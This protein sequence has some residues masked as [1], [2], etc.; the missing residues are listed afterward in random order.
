[1]GGQ[2]KKDLASAEQTKQV[3]AEEIGKLSSAL[4][5][6]KEK[7]QELDQLNEDLE[8]R[9]QEQQQQQLQHSKMVATEA[10]P[11]LQLQEVS[12]A[13]GEEIPALTQANTKLQQEVSTLTEQ[14][15]QTRATEA[16]GKKAK[17][18]L[19]QAEQQVSE[20]K[21][22][23]QEAEEKREAEIEVL[24]THIQRLEAERSEMEE[25]ISQLHQSS[26]KVATAEVE[27][28]VPKGPADSAGDGIDYN[29]RLEHMENEKFSMNEQ[30]KDLKIQVLNKQGEVGELKT[31]L[32]MCLFFRFHSIL[33]H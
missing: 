23:T 12:P 31:K 14:L 24:R 8:D 25:K 15:R 20:L 13:Q 5:R 3:H 10:P 4:E 32:G 29:L 19:L 18:S 21:A 16:E 27:A 33:V 7:V 22:A 11:Q 17:E 30:I 6:E 1:M 2:L 9:L 28:S 26:A